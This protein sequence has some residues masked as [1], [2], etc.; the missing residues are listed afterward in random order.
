MGPDRR[1]QCSVVA[2]SA[3]RPFVGRVP[4]L[5]ALARHLA[6]AGDGAGRIVLVSGDPGIGKTRLV[7]QALSACPPGRLL[8]GRC[9]EGAGAP[10]YW[11]WIE[12]LRRLVEAMPA[13][14]LGRALGSGAAEVA[15]VLPEIRARLPR[16]APPPFAPLDTNEA[17]FRLFDALGRFV[18]A[19][20]ADPLVVALD[21]LHW[22]DAESLLLLR[23]L[24]PEIRRSHLLVIATCREV[25]M[26][27]AAGPPNIYGDLV[28]LAERV[29]LS[30]LGTDEIADYVRASSGRGASPALVAAI[31]RATSGNPFFVA[32]LVDLLDRDGLLGSSRLRVDQL[33]LPVGVR[34]AILQ[35]MERLDPDAKRLLQI[36]AVAGPEFDT[37]VIAR[38]AG[39][40]VSQVV[41]RLSPA[42][43]GRILTDAGTVPGRLRFVQDLVGDALRAEIDPD[44]RASLHRSVADAI[45]AVHEHSLDEI[46]GEVAR[47]LLAAGPLGDLPRAIA[48]AT[49]AGE[50]ALRHLGYEEAAGHHE[51]ALQAALAIDIEPSQRLELSSRLADARLAAGDDDGARSAAIDA[52]RLAREAGDVQRFARAAAIASAARSETGQP[53]HAVIEILEESVRRAGTDRGI[54]ALVLPPCSRELY[55]VDRARRHA[56]SEAGL[57]HARA[58]GNPVLLGS[59]LG[60]RHLALWEPGTARERLVLADEQLALAEETQDFQLAMHGHAWRIADLL[61]LGEVD[62][63]NEALV[64]YEALAE[65]R[66]LPRLSWHVAI[67][68][69]SRALRLGQLGEAER[70]ATTAFSTWQSG[71]QNNVLQF[72]AIQLYLIREAQ[73]RL[74]ELDDSLQGFATGSITPAWRAAIAS[75]HATLG[76][77]EQARQVLNDLLA[78]GV[79]ALPLDGTWI[80]M[81]IRLALTCTMLEESAI[82]GE[83]LPRLAPFADGNVV[84]GAGVASLGSVERYVGL[85]A[86]TAGRVEEALRHLESALEANRRGRFHAQVAHV[87]VELARALR[88]AG[89]QP[90][91]VALEAEAAAAARALGL[92]AVLAQ[93][94]RSEAL[95]ALAGAPRTVTSATPSEPGYPTI[96][97]LQRAGEVWT[98]QHAEEITRLRDMKGV[99]YLVQL[100]RYPGREFHALDVIGSDLESGRDASEAGGADL[101]ATYGERLAD[102]RD[103]LIEAESFNDRARAERASCEMEALAEELSRSAGVG[104]GSRRA[105]SMAE[106]ARLNA[107][108][109]IRKVIARIEADCP[110]LGRHLSTSVQTGR[111][112]CYREDPTFPVTWRL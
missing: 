51:R 29:P 64:R 1:R 16:I 61:E 70:L 91:A 37:A 100:L 83:L 9:H 85:L 75:L 93:L 27:E 107:T 30:G 99:Q 86:L 106:R 105:G 52:A 32:E 15:R 5:G 76:R 31:H 67:A 17:R 72:Y 34:D 78:P 44:L 49:R 79:D 95:A 71:P 6:A 13:D 109:A 19:V 55:F 84:I 7:E 42:L 62:A 43:A 45:E 57:V 110:R 36:A 73:G 28:R 38:V 103:E 58:L 22:A 101:R 3:D 35:R 77:A 11:P 20:A 69:T 8:W 81:M 102:L 39:L 96:A 4:E 33:A 68:R 111:L 40:G 74:A 26:G 98:V 82:A 94:E 50:R 25:E 89:A 108:R 87:Q 59:A 48:H 2:T 56:L 10:A 18:Y 12:A 47:H 65:R 92:G 41:E 21:G 46:A 90:R 88:L 53:D 112:C 60:A 14:D 54:L 24:G 97:A 66:R 23:F 104:I 80:P 63:A